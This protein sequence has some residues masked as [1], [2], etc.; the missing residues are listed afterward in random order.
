MPNMVWHLVR[1]QSGVMWTSITA[2][3]PNMSGGCR[4]LFHFTYW[5]P[6]WAR[7]SPLSKVTRKPLSTH[8]DKQDRHLIRGGIQ[9]LY[10]VC[11]VKRPIVML[12]LV[13]YHTVCQWSYHTKHR[14]STKCFPKQKFAEHNKSEQMCSQRFIPG[15]PAGNSTAECY[16]ATECLCLHA[17]TESTRPNPQELPKW[18]NKAAWPRNCWLHPFFAWSS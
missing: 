11:M 4:Y 6:I 9:H 15:R 5:I 14:G 8:T 10:C 2:L 17:L 13:W 7:R 16:R 18:P 12:N 1:S 3:A